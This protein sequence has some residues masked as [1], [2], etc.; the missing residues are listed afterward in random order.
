VGRRV[1]TADGLAVRTCRRL[2]IDQ[3]WPNYFIVG[4]EWTPIVLVEA[5][6]EMN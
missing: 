4:R 6:Y 3:P 5:V 2:S 1:G